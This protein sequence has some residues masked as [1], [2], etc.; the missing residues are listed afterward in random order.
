MI[1]SPAQV[2]K[3]ILLDEDLVTAHDSGQDWACFVSS[4]PDAPDKC[5]CAYD[6]AASKDG[7]LM[8]GEV[9]EHPG[10]MLHVRSTD[11]AS[12]W[13]KAK[14]IEA[15]LDTVIKRT[16]VGDTHTY[17]IHS[18]RRPS[19]I[20]PMGAEPGTRRR[21]MFSINLLLTIKTTTNP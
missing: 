19:S 8:Q 2:I 18:V 21:E 16:V 5:V 10:V 3:Q 6:T 9:I 13:A 11:Y 17:L 14:A 12:G 1:L 20:L 15:E 4:M 7:R